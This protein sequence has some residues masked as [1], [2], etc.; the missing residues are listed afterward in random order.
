MFVLR[1]RLDIAQTRWAFMT[2]NLPLFNKTQG[3]GTAKSGICL[4]D[5]QPP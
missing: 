4:D 5:Y 3:F 2:P 1:W